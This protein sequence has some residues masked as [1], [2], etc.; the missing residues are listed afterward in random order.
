MTVLSVAE[1]QEVVQRRR[2][3]KDPPVLPKHLNFFT[4]ILR[5]YFILQISTEMAIKAEFYS[6]FCIS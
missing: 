1:H 2:Q 5:A 4:S 6:C 3:A